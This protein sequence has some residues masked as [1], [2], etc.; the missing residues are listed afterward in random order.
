MANS[1]TN[2]RIKEPASHSENQKDKKK[3][4]KPANKALPINA[5][6]T[7]SSASYSSSSSVESSM[8]EAAAAAGGSLVGNNED[9]LWQIFPYLSPKSLLRFQCVSRQWL[10]I[11]SDPAFRILHARTYP[12]TTSSSSATTGLILHVRLPWLETYSFNFISFHEDYKNSMHHIISNFSDFSKG[13]IWNFD[14]CNGLCAMRLSILKSQCRHDQVVVYNPSTRQHRVI[15][16]EIKDGYIEGMNIVFDPLKSDHFKLVL[17]RRV[18][19]Y[20]YGLDKYIYHVYASQTGVWRRSEGTKIGWDSA[21]FEKGVVWNGDLHWMTHLGHTLCFDLDNA[22]LRQNM[23]PLLERPE[24][25]RTHILF[26]GVSGENLCAIGDKKLGTLDLDVYELERDYSKWNVKYYCLCSLGALYPS[27]MDERW[28]ILCMP[29]DKEDKSATLVICLDEKI[30]Y[31]DTKNMT[32]TDVKQVD[33]QGCRRP[34]GVS[35]Y[36]WT[37]AYQHMETLACL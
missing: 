15:P 13:K 5:V 22:T 35:A 24:H 6:T 1:V 30:I 26:F 36:N 33:N 27:L 37:E 14:S 19:D 2:K 25:A 21:Y 16:L 20:W 12:A 8:A 29:V 32:V 34:L 7:S 10:S 31:Y 18:E 28:Q 9:L 4:T 11:I 23:P 3:E 17:V